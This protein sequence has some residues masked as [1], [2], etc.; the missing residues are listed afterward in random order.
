MALEHA[1]GNEEVSA[2]CQGFIGGGI[3]GEALLLLHDSS[4]KDL[5]VLL[6]HND[7]L[8]AAAK[9][10]LLTDTASL[11]TGACLK[12]LA[13]QLDIS[14]SL[15]HPVLLGQHGEI[16]ELVRRNAERWKNVLTIEL[17]FTIEHHN[18]SANLMLLFAN[19]SLDT[20]RRHLSYQVD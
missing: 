14:L 19:G 5:A 13:D 1:A 8:N 20:M 6:H 18:I 3:A 9:V 7:E 4:Y 12:G 17:G 2:L 10:E 11:P 15:S 16:N